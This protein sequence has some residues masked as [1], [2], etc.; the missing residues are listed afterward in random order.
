MTTTAPK[1]S[2]NFTIMHQF[3][4]GVPDPEA[5]PEEFTA[6][7]D[8]VG[9]DKLIE[10][11]DTQEPTSNGVITGTESGLEFFGYAYLSPPGH[12]QVWMSAFRDRSFKS[13]LLAAARFSWKWL[14]QTPEMTDLHSEYVAR[15][16]EIESR[17]GRQI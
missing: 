8:R 6:A 12:L 17:T 9:M 13:G 5:G 10:A 4:S 2:A 1:L 16:R 11:L 3:L 14:E 15:I 7:L